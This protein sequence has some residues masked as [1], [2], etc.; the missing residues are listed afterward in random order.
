MQQKQGYFANIHLYLPAI[1][2][3]TLGIV[4]IYSIKPDNALAQVIIFGVSLIASFLISKLQL[5]RGWLPAWFWYLLVIVSLV[6]TSLFGSASR[7]SA[8]WITLFNQQLQTSEFA[9]IGIILFSATW[10]SRIN[11]RNHLSQLVRYGLLIL[12][13]TFLIFIQPD[14][15]T[16]LMLLAIAV[17]TIILSG[18]S[19]KHILIVSLVVALSLPLMYSQLKPYQKDRITSFINPATDPLGSGYNSLQSTIAVG[20]GMFFGR[21][22]GRG[23]QSHLRFLPERHTDFIFASF[24]E[25]MGF[26]GGAAVMALYAW[27]AYGLILN[28]KQAETKTASLV[29][30]L[31]AALILIQATINMGMNMGIVPITGVTLPFMSYGGSSLLSMYILLGINSKV[32]NKK[33]NTYNS[34]HLQ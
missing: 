10:F 25:E 20:S 2:L 24:V 16:S 9:K 32:V 3:T 14:L 1:A 6:A 17:S 21:G 19:F 11:K 29:S 22:L 5:N 28:G 15:G 30:L 27:L 8:R 34:L 13:P 26:V 31:S 23:T 18:T 33:K 4:T 12:L 7:G